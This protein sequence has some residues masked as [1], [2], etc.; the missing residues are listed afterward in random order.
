MAWAD[1]AK[2]RERKAF[3][4]TVRG[5]VQGVGF[6]WWVCS[7]AERHSITGWVENR[8]DG[9]VEIYAEGASGAL[10]RFLIEAEKGPPLSRVESFTKRPC[11]PEGLT[12][13]NVRGY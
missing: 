5:R 12:G 9:S 8:P 2:P 3:R 7:A 4:V 11:P 10:G 13:F 1:F 6:R